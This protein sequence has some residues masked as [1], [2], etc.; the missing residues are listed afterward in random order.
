MDDV[1][2]VLDAVG[3]RQA[4]LLGRLRGRPAVRA[5]RHHLPG[6]DARAGDDRHLRASG[7]GRPTIR[8]RRRASR[9][10]A[11]STRS[12][13]TWGGA[14]G[15][16]ARAPSVA[17]DPAFR[18]WWSTY[19]RMGASPGAAL[20]LTRMNADDR[21]APRAAGDPRADADPAPHRGSAADDRR[22]PL[23]RLAD[24]RRHAGRAARR[25]SPAVRRRPGRHA[26][27]HRALP[28]RTGTTPSTPTACWRPSVTATIDA[29]GP[30]GTTGLRGAGARR[31]R[32]PPRPPAGVHARRRSRPP[33]TVRRGPSAA[34]RRWS[35]RARA[36]SAPCGPACTPASASWS[37]ARCAASPS[38]CRATWRR[39]PGAGEVL[40]SRTLVDLVAGS[41]LEFESRGPQPFGAN[42][43][44]FEIF[45]RPRPAP[46]DSYRTLTGRSGSLRLPAR[47]VGRL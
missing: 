47:S 29:A 46:P 5:L 1:R 19:L 39:W 41:G 22:G 14:V 45:A 12:Q 31:H 25:G 4:A 6:A 26:R 2:A 21:R 44:R 30:G 37:P 16:E 34:P 13:R 17:H 33:S 23:R 9:A 7:A 18:D 3:S 35:R 42:G 10:S 20:A 8:G 40:V 28:R 43:D 15:L 24:P 32:P 36:P 27:R 11:S 38:T